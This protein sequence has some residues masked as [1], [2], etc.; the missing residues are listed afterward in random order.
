TY[1][2]AS[3]TAPGKVRARVIRSEAAVM[4][5]VRAPCVEAPRIAS[6]YRS[7]IPATERGLATARARPQACR[8]SVSSNGAQYR[9]A[10]ALVMIVSDEYQGVAR[11]ASRTR[12]AASTALRWLM[13]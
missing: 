13:V 8:S 11:A 4:R 2:W 5:V 3:L 1:A 12:R 7:R 9:A 10:R 6:R